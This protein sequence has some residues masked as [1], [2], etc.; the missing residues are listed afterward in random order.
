MDASRDLQKF[1]FTEEVI[2]HFRENRIIPVDFYNKHGQI[3]IHKKDM[4]SGDDISRL[5][6]F[7]K[8]GIYF[9][10]SEIAKIH[11]GSGKKSSSLDPSFDKLINAGLTLDMSRGASD[12]LSEIKKFPL[13]GAH[14][15]EINKSI[16]AVLEDFKSSPNMET[17]LVNII[18]VMNSAGAPVDSEVL[19]KRT[20]I[21]M[22]LKLRSA[23]AFTKADM[24]QKKTE[25][26][27]LMMASYLADIGYTQMKIPTHANLKP[28]ELEYIKNHP[29]IS[30]LMIAN[31]PEIEDP[32]KSVVLNHHRPHRG[33]GMNNN[34]PQTKPLVQKLQGYREK[35]KE[36]FRKNLLATDIQR[37]VKNILT[38]GIPYDDIGILS[39]AGEFASL[40]TPQP[41]RDP[42]DGLKAMK[43]ILNNSFFAYNEKTLKDFFD[44]VGL[45]LCENQPFIKIGDYVIVASQDSN[46]KVFFEICVIK[47]SHK[48]SI[49]PMLERIGTIRPK[50]ANNGKIRIS[51][52]EM[53][54]L[55]ID[56]R[57]AVFNLERNADP[58]RI[59]Y[60]VDPG[61]DPEFFDSLDRVVRETYPSRTS[62]DSDNASKTAVS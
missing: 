47:D 14:V 20:V 43:L 46:R 28:E 51:G 38:N 33:E 17:G 26:M 48:N 44:H 53:D 8:Q 11:P 21:A 1:D 34:Y 42:M 3:L 35:Y 54:S 24:E 10:T 23:K 49:R 41:W 39:I 7:E 12:I 50:F 36:D 45:S 5:Q 18:E 22:A 9:L 37:Q 6:K 60:L 4:A 61:L 16:N 56:R 19:T 40:T 29:I 31:L 27:N 57:R 15:K 55:H 25:Q 32:V 59:I 52:F 30:Y 58:R 13:N 2:Q 62:S